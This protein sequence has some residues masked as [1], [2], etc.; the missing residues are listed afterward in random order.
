M[1]MAR[2]AG[3]SQK[4]IE[5]DNAALG[6][7]AQGIPQQGQPPQHR[8]QSDDPGTEWGG[9]QDRA[10]QVITQESREP[11]DPQQSGPQPS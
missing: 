9:E 8:D 3:A 2:D 6:Q 11:H 4:S 5:T 10:C 1:V 7:V